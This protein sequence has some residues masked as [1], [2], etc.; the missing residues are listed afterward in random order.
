MLATR[1][2]FA[3]SL[4]CFGQGSLATGR[5]CQRLSCLFSGRIAFDYCQDDSVGNSGALEASECR[6]TCVEVAR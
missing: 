1:P 5:L 4:R 6:R 2:R 3:F